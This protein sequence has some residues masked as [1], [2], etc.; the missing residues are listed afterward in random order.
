MEEGGWVGTGLTRNI[1]VC[2]KSSQNSSK[3]VGPTDIL[4]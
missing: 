4:E 2:G 1:F 3:A